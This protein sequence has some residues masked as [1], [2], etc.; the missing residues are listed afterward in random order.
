VKGNLKIVE[1]K[2]QELKV[3]FQKPFEAKDHIAEI[4]QVSEIIQQQ[5]GELI[6]HFQEYAFKHDFES[7]LWKS[8]FH[9]IITKFRWVYLYLFYL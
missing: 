2:Q 6:V 8:A 3:M 7:A 1:N 5:Y 9:N 4:M